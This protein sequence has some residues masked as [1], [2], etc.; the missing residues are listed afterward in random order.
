MIYGV[1][2]SKMRKYLYCRGFFV[3]STESTRTY[4]AKTKN[5]RHNI[6]KISPKHFLHGKKIHGF[7]DTY[8]KKISLATFSIPNSFKVLSGFRF[9]FFGNNTKVL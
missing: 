3:D 4:L 5:R 1:E 6:R 7:W 2:K 9:Y 8:T